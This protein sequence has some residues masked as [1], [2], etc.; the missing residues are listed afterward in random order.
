MNVLENSFH[1]KSHEVS[2]SEASTS[3]ASADDETSIYDLASNSDSNNQ[4]QDKVVVTKEENDTVVI[5]DKSIYDDTPSIYD[6]PKNN[7]AAGNSTETD[8]SI[9]EVTNEKSENS[10]SMLEN[11][12][13]ETYTYSTSEKKVS[14]NLIADKTIL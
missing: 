14:K 9:Y 11:L 10:K 1:L 8:V 6:Q 2:S 12:S 4:Q 13:N 5:E 7:E 3:S